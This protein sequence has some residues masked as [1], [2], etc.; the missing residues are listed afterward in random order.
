MKL[1]FLI[2]MAAASGDETESQIRSRYTSWDSFYMIKDVKSL[3][4][5]LDSRFTLVNGHAMVV[6][7]RDY[8]SR[9]WQASLPEK[10]ETQVLRLKS[11]KDRVI[12]WTSELSQK[13]GSKPAEHLY[14]DTWVNRKGTWKLLESR[15]TG[16]H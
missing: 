15:T 4:G 9:L 16:G 1:L 3:A 10:Y 12:V 7:R 6:S 11:D 2:A 13:P 8:V 14:R 5:M